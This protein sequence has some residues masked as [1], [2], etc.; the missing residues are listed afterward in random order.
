MRSEVASLLL[1]TPTM[2]PCA[3]MLVPPPTVVVGAVRCPWVG[4][5]PPA[6]GCPAACWLAYTGWKSPLVIG[7]LYF[8]LRKCPSSRICTFGGN[9][10]AVYYTHL[11]AHETPEH[12]V[13]R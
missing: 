9:V 4:T 2:P 11:R 1:A 6:F 3:P 8:F 10:L 13:C 12:L 7:S 5:M